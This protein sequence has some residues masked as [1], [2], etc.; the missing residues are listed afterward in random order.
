M[1]D[2]WTA[3]VSADQQHPHRLWQSLDQLMGRGH[4]PPSTLNASV[5]HTFFDDKIAGVRAATAGAGEP[6][7]TAA[8]VGCEMRLFTPVTT[9]DVMKMI[10]SLPDKQCLTD[11]MPTWLLK[12][13][14]DLLA[15]FL[16][17]LFNWSLEHG[18][19]PVSMKAAYITPTVKKAGMDPTDPKSYRPISNLSVISKLLER[20]V[21]QQLLTYLRNNSLLPDLQSAFRAHHS[22]E[23]AV[24][25][26][27]TD[28]LLALDSGNLAL[29][30]LLDLSAAFD[31]VD[32]ATLIKRL[33][34]SY[35]LCGST[36]RW[37]RSYLTGRTQYVRTSVTSSKP[38]TVLY[39]VPQG[40]VLGPLL[41]LLYTADV[42]QLVKDRGLLPHA[43]AD[44]T[45]ILGVC[46]PTETEVL[47]RRV[48]DCLDAVSS[49]MAANRLQLNHE[50]TEALWCSSERR[51]HQ[52]PT[53]PVRVGCTSV[54]PVTAARNLG[55]YLDGDVSMRTHVTSTVRACFAILRQIRSIRHS[56]PR[57]A[58][59][60]MLRSLVI[61]K[62]DSCGSVMAGA[63]D[64]L[65]HRLQSVLNAAVRLV[66]SARKFD[67]TTPLL[68]ELHWLK[69]PERV[70]FRLCVLTYRCLNGTAPHYLAETIHPVSSRGSRHLRSAYTS[71]LLV[72]STRRSTLGDRSFPVA[73]ARA[74]NALPRHVRNAA[75][76]PAFRRELKSVL[77]RSSFPAA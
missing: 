59:L 33:E 57:P 70:K 9:E 28:I 66:F 25:K 4:A 23:T 29:L 19:V 7:F 68:R 27:L 34:T 2:F 24:L 26:V 46:R 36:L 3:R 53:T 63:P 74:W 6:T 52:I 71:T 50:K 48:S 51:Q 38:C 15:P 5:H 65:L 47:Q 43:Y 73:A 64:V 60:T 69:V 40:S 67:H 30:T 62:L 21:S 20:L 18:T 61:N 56:L 32:H 75:S 39:G 37:I 72:P 12:T 31:S 1:T 42:L 13:N 58:M 10:R 54:Q 55:V 44:D 41:F 22:T 45:Q 14:V 8:P 49:W 76:L 11:P 17:Q 77:F 16:C 35:G